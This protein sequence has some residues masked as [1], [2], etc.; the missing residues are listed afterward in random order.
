MVVGWEL[1]PAMK[2]KLHT[3][4]LAITQL[5]SNYMLIRKKENPPRRS[6]TSHFQMLLAW[7][8]P[9]RSIKQKAADLALS[10]MLTLLH[11]IVLQ[12]N[13]TKP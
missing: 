5:S 9:S 6:I 1:W 11:I 4:R 3:G 12:D 7:E 10:S 13:S 8:K 2:L